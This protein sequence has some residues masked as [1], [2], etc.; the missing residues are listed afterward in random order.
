MGTACELAVGTCP[1]GKSSGTGTSSP[2]LCTLCAAGQYQPNAGETS[3][4]ECPEG[5]AKVVGTE[6]TP[7]TT[8][9]IVCPKGYY[10]ASTT[11]SAICTECPLGKF[12]T[13]LGT[14]GTS[15]SDD[16]TQCNAGMYGD[17]LALA[18]P[19]ETYDSY[20]LLI[21][22]GLTSRLIIFFFF[23]RQKLTSFYMYLLLSLSF[24]SLSDP[25]SR[26]PDLPIFPSSRGVISAQVDSSQAP[27]TPE[28]RASRMRARS[29]RRDMPSRPWVH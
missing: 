8:P 22:V 21:K 3:C 18:S 16:C 10:T 20:G 27:A 9:C 17:Q 4:I 26:S 28:R 24:L 13:R 29:A 7:A 23:F 15:T 1:A 25:I 11:A 12:S 5:R 19:I 14:K 2:N 6:A